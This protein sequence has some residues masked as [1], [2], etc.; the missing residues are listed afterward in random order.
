[1]RSFFGSLALFLCALV[2]ASA[3]AVHVFGDSHAKYSFSTI[4]SCTIHW[5]GPIT[6][7]RVGRDG[8][9]GLN[10]KSY[11]VQENDVVIFVFGEIDVRCHV[12]PQCQKGRTLDDVLGQL[13]TKYIATIQENRKQYQRLHPVIFAVLP[14]IRLVGSADYPSRGTVEERIAATRA[15]NAHLH[16]AA[17]KEGIDVIDVHADFSTKEGL[18]EPKLSDGN[19][20]MNPACNGPVRRKLELLIGGYR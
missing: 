7:H 1:M 2:Q 3:A 20:H 19:V 10:I 13:I 11:G 17:E 4:P 14:P 16:A 18:L 9:Q 6:M 5:L 15:L 8:L 12:I